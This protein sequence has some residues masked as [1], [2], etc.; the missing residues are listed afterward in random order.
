MVRTRLMTTSPGH[1][2]SGN[3][4]SHPNRAHQ[5]VP[6]MQSPSIQKIQS[7]AATMA[8]LTR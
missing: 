6:F 7:M 8:K 3:V 2:E 1:Q 4:S 5:S